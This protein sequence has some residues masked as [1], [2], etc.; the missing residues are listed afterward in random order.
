MPI[1][2]NRPAGTVEAMQL[3]GTAAGNEAVREWVRG[4]PGEPAVAIPNSMSWTI[5]SVT[6]PDGNLTASGN[7][8]IYW[9]GSKIRA[10]DKQTFELYFIP[11]D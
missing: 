6:T 9:D 5:V 10:V 7:Q 3:D 4:L 8:Y 11:A 1:F 2:E